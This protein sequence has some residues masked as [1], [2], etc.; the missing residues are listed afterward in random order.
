MPRNGQRRLTMLKKVEATARAGMTTAIRNAQR[1]AAEA[2]ARAARDKG[3]LTSERR[4]KE[5]FSAVGGYYD[6]LEREL[7][8]LIK[9]ATY[10][11]A[12]WFHEEAVSDVRS[13]RKNLAAGVVMFDRRR[14]DAVWQIVAPENDRGLAAVFTDKMTK[15]QI[16][17]LRQSLVEVW[18]EADVAG[19]TLNER[20]ALVQ[21]KWDQLAG[22]V[23]SDRFVDRAGRAWANADYLNM[24]MRTT[25][26]RVAR[27]SYFDTLTKAGFDLAIIENVDGEACEVCQAWGGKIISISGSTKEYPSYQLAMDAG[28]GHPNCRCTAEYIDETQIPEAAGRKEAEVEEEK[29]VEPAPVVSARIPAVAPPKPTKTEQMRAELA[30]MQKKTAEAKAEMLAV[31]S[32]VDALNTQLAEKEAAIEAMKKELAQLQKNRRR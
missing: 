8:A 27:D 32:R 23:L 31:R 12:K 21:S 10:Q 20:H 5:A 15:A 17:A 13:A 2:I 19:L 11:S 9:D 25:C 1:G 18:R 22:N 14:V 4:R 29:P 7:T 16:G 6:R 26:A 30:D 3:I 24:L 28:W